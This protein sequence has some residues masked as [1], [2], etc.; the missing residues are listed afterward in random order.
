MG[1]RLAIWIAAPGEEFDAP[2]GADT[3]SAYRLFFE[4]RQTELQTRDLVI[5]NTGSTTVY[6]CWE[7][8]MPNRRTGLHSHVLIDDSIVSCRVVCSRIPCQFN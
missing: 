2:P 7:V 8:P 4:T 5:A 3:R 1:P 6:F